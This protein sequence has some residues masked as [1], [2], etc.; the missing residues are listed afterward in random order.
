MHF[1]SGYDHSRCNC[2]VIC[3]KLVNVNGVGAF[4]LLLPEQNDLFVTFASQFQLHTGLTA[5]IQ[6]PPNS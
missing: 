1:F 3:L 5:R 6:A 2:I 4:P